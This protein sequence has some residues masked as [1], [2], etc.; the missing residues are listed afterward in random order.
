[1]KNIPGTPSYRNQP[2]RSFIVESRPAFLLFALI[3]EGGLNLLCNSQDAKNF[4]GKDPLT[5][6]SKIILPK[7]EGRIDH[8]A[9]DP[10]N[11][12]VF[13][14]ALGNN[15]VEIV[16]IMTGKVGHTINGLHEPQGVAYIP[17]EKKLVV[18]NGGNGDC[19]F[20]DAPLFTQSAVV[21][22]KSDADNIRYDAVSNLLYV[23]HGDGA[24]AVIDPK[25]MKLIDDIPLD[26]HPESF[27]ISKKQNRIYINV[28]DADEIEV[29]ELSAHK[30]ISKWRNKIASSNFPMALD[31]T[32][33]R[34]F[35]G[36]RRPSK[37]KMIN[38]KT[39]EGLFA[40]NGSGDADDVFYNPSDSLVF[41]SAGQGYIDVFKAG[42]NELVQTTR[43]KTGSG[44]RT[45]L[46]VP[47]EKKFLL[48]APAHGGDPAALWVYNLN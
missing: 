11:H 15:T 5:L 35:I 31:E 17:S 12:L 25:S 36:C 22:L 10:A 16:N 21:L 45:S 2:L 42:K 47:E 43:I 13:I 6:V 37:L 30:I 9:Y 19:L 41:V 32:G 27:Q 46:L 33:N 28:P 8:M 18:A 38:A 1:M 26:G 34:L 40:I 14:A 23:G 48:A 20:F 44:A 24:L 39:G 3:L 4:S 7:V 29:M